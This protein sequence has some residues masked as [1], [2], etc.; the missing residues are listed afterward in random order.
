MIRLLL[1]VPGLAPTYLQAHSPPSSQTLDAWLSS[2]GGI[3]AL[4]LL[5]SGSQQHSRYPGAKSCLPHSTEPVFRVPT[6]R[7][8]LPTA[9]PFFLHCAQTSPSRRRSQTRLHTPSVPLD[10]NYSWAPGKLAEAEAEA[11]ALHTARLSWPRAH[12]PLTVHQ[13]GHRW[14]CTK[15]PGPFLPSAE[16]C[17]GRWGGTYA[18][19]RP[20][21]ADPAEQKETSKEVEASPSAESSGRQQRAKADPQQKA[22]GLVIC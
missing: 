16:P 2:S 1:S 22:G 7:S 12:T 5:G 4:P 10:T 3:Q 15:L 11:E 18:E 21:L 13:S 20:A 14:G 6:P 9:L 19:G 17:A 8:K